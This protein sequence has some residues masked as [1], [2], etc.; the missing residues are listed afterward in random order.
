MSISFQR[1]FYAIA[2]IF[3]MFAFLILAKVILIPL[4]FALLISFILY[5]V[6]KRFEKW[7]MNMIIA[8]LLSIILV[9]SIFV[10][11]IYLFSRQLIVLSNNIS[12]FQDRLVT[13]F[14]DIT[15]FINKNFQFIDN[16]GK[17]EL[18]DKIKLWF[19]QSSGYLA[20]ETFSSTASFIGGFFLA[21]VYIF[22]FLIYRRG[23]VKALVLFFPIDQR[24]QVVGMFKKVQQVGKKYLFGMFTMVAIIGFINS[25][26][27]WIIGI[28]NPFLFGFLGA[29]MSIVPYVGTVLGAVIPVLY[30][31]VSYDTIWPAI[32]VAILF[33]AVQLLTDNFLAPRIV[34]GSLNVNAF[35]AIFSLIVGASVWGVAGM[36]L[37]LPIAAILRVICDEYSQLRPI[38][39]LI[40]EQNVKKSKDNV[41]IE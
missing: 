35:T 16:I 40:G 9:F 10:L 23:F 6:C 24:S 7:G 21:I 41:P 28:D 17:D 29:I 37:F 13:L 3:A 34:G 14:A 5:P 20:T 30:A 32:S 8:A 36:I 31:V 15:L 39:L 27:L 33:W 12:Q 25:I 4:A 18:F 1:L 11:G 22:L 2:T 19:N 26:G 38:A